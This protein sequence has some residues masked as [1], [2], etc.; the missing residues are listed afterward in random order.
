MQIPHTDTYPDVTGVILAGG[1]SRRMGTD[2]AQLELS[3]Q[4]L[5]ERSLQLLQSFFS[6]IIIAGDR[7][8]LVRPGIPAIADL[9]PGSALGGLHTGLKTATTDW[10]FVAPCDMP[11]PDARIVAAL[12]QNRQGV[13]AVVPRTASGYEPVFA[14]YHKN[15]LPQMEAML[16]QNQF[17]IYDFYQRIAIRYLEPPQLPDGWQRSL[18][19]IN[20]PEQLAQIKKESQ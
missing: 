4:S 16:Q 18:I 1:K 19:N 12:L 5:F 13:D 10:I 20:T 15:C 7:P 3:G 14:L 9:Y 2:K 17:R 6:R 8:D 11:F